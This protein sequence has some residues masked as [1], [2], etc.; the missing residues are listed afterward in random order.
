MLIIT[1]RDFE[2]W[3]SW[4]LVYEWEDELIK[5]L[6]DSKLF[7]A[8]AVCIK[9]RNTLDII[10]RKTGINLGLIGLGS[11]EG[12]YFSM[13]PCLSGNA[14]NKSNLSTNIIDFYLKEEQLPAFYRNYSKLRNLYV[15]SREVYEFLMAH[16]PER[17][18][19]HLPLTI[20]DK[21]KITES[22][23]F[24]K[25]FDV[26]MVGRQN[27]TMVDFLH[28]YER[29]HPIS[30]VYRGKIKNN[31]FPYYTNKGKYVG[32]VN[33]RED[34]FNLIR[35]SRVVLYSTPGLEKDERESFN[36]GFHQ[37]TPRFLEA[38]AGGCRVISLFI[39]N[40]DTDFFE[41][42]KMSLRVK[43]YNDFEIAMNQAIEEPADMKV[44]SNYLKKHYTS[45]YKNLL[46]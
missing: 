3:P 43:D 13:S 22:T 15:S 20:S 17:E 42:G 36:N 4:D 11:R 7:H 10:G 44:Y 37:V 34:Y 1:K 18:I 31:N 8:K 46:Q 38:I 6:P 16:N 32:N 30:Y 2:H 29:M 21:Y 9:G 39:D 24:D 27:P 12:F 14:W 23:V 45:T 28:K 35:Q 5:D 40:S 26:V 25:N 41:L 19:K 33:T